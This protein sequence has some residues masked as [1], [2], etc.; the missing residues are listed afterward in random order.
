[1][2]IIETRSIHKIYPNGVQSHPIPRPLPQLAR[3]GELL[4]ERSAFE[5]NLQLQ[6]TNFSLPSMLSVPQW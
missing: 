4:D 3:E 1:M 5:G 2:P 6:E